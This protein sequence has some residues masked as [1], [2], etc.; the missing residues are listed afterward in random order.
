MGGY[1]LH[2]CKQ[3]WERMRLGQAPAYSPLRRV[4][5][6]SNE[7]VAA[8]GFPPSTVAAGRVP[9]PL[10]RA[11]SLPR[12]NWT[13]FT[14]RVLDL[15]C[16][17]SWQAAVTTLSMKSSAICNSICHGRRTSTSPVSAEQLKLGGKHENKPSGANVS[18]AYATVAAL[19]NLSQS[20][21]ADTGGWSIQQR[22][23]SQLPPNA[24]DKGPLGRE[25]S[26]VSSLCSPR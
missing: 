2:K 5:S 3:N 6:G 26:S 12:C 17:A 9:S 21:E 11:G 7:S 24:W 19:K 1:R 8:R 22:N 16:R 25:K 20:Q 18:K 14:S 15:R 23:A 10:V 13:S 4:L